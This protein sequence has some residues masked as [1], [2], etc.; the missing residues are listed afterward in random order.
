MSLRRHPERGSAKRAAAQVISNALGLV[1]VAAQTHDDDLKIGNF[2]RFL[3]L[4]PSMPTSGLVA[5]SLGTR[6]GHLVEFRQVSFRYPGSQ[7]DTLSQGPTR[8]SWWEEDGTPAYFDF[9]LGGT[10]LELS[11]G[12]WNPSG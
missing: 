7:R 6:S 8:N 4:E 3:A 5:P 11:N 2:R 9:R 10:H 12:G 1:Y